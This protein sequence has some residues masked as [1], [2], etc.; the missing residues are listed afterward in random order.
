MTPEQRRTHC[1]DLAKAFDVRL[2][3]DSKLPPEH[4]R[5]DV[6]N[7]T[8]FSAPIADETIYAVVLHEM[9]HVL[10]PA[11]A[12]RT[13]STRLSSGLMLHEEQAAWEWAQHYAIEWTPAMD[14]VKAWALSTY[15]AGYA[16][17]VRKDANARRP[18][19]TP[20]KRVVDASDFATQIHWH[21]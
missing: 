14:A 19:I 5:A 13:E 12:L 8:V 17:H 6:A 15:Q 18:A 7:R 1:H 11:G 3:E 4:A 16:D 10:A 20:Q 2:I 21:S 9:G